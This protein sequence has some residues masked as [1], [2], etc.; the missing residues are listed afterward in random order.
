MPAFDYARSHHTVE[1][2]KEEHLRK[3][4]LLP[5]NAPKMK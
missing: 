1:L 5:G 3:K 4:M 2:N